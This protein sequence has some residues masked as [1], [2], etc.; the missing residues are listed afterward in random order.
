MEGSGFR[1][2][3]VRIAGDDFMLATLI[4]NV[5]LALV[6]A[7]EVE[8]NAMVSP[9]AGWTKGSWVAFDASDSLGGTAKLRLT[10]IAASDS[11][12][13]CRS[14]VEGPDGP[15]ERDSV[16][17]LAS[18]GYPHAHPDGQR[19]GEATL[20]VGGKSYDCDVWRARYL[21]EGSEC[22]VTAWIA[23]EVEQPL[24]IRIKG[25]MS[26]DLDVD[27]VEDF[28]KVGQ[29]KFKSVRYVGSST[30]EGKR[31]TVT[32]WRSAAVP[33]ALVRSQVVAPPEKG[34]PGVVHTLEL[35]E[36]RGTR[37]D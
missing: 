19:I 31:A 3:V 22:E 8:P 15:V 28:V 9:W 23:G 4:L 33:G 35:R 1:A 14:L 2:R 25:R 21:E 10:M 13:T 37:L 16:A 32:Q 7:G 20:I 5:G 29:R 27:K 24:R 11:T 30:F 36:F 6:A 18:L 17:S 26:F 12:Y 34:Q